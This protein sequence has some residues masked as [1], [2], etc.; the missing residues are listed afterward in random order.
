MWLA[1]GR[2]AD[3]DAMPSGQSV[4][5][6]SPQTTGLAAGKWCPY[7]MWPDQPLDQRAETGGQAVFDSEPLAA[8]FEILGLP[9]LE[10][11]VAADRPNGIVAVTLCEVFPDGA[12][13]RVTYGL[14]NLSHRDSH[15]T[16]QPLEI[17]RRYSIA[18]NL[19]AVGHRFGRGNRLRVAVSTAYWPI[20]WPSPE[21]LTLTVFCSESRL[22]LPVR[23]PH[24]L[25]RALPPMPEPHASAKLA[26]MI[27]KQGGTTW[28]TNLDAYTG[29]VVL[30][31]V[32]DDGVRRIEGIGLEV[33]FRSEHDYS[34]KADDPLSARLETR[35]RRHYRRGDWRVSSET[36]ILLTS[37][38]TQFHLVARLVAFEGDQQ[39]VA[40]DWKVEIARDLV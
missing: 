14:L 15:E 21:P 5:V 1:P 17:G 34:I 22:A 24:A 28:N 26:Q 35:Y 12:A 39:V 19:N 31:R 6:S 20:V 30:R 11:D 13:T 9:V 32:A 10:L 8:D 40:K 3:S 29:E 2:L 18:V 27:V 4:T 7:C 38:A 23:V 36:R 25:D 33:G 16:P 37:T